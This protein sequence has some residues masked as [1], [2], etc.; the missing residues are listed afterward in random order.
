MRRSYKPETRVVVS[1]GSGL[2]SG[3]RGV[4]IR[5]PWSPSSPEWQRNEPGRYKPFDSTREVAIRED[6]TGQVF[7]M[8][9]ANLNMEA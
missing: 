8:F 1:E 7:T 4:I 9:K 6:V 5:P 3:R 2:D